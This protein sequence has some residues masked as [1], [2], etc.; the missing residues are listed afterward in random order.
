[1]KKIGKILAYFLAILLILAVVLI[2]RVDRQPYQETAYYQNTMARIDALSLSLDPADSVLQAGWSLTNMTPDEPAPLVGYS[3]RGDY[4]FVADSSFIRTLLLSSAREQ[5]VILGYDLLIVHPYLA[6]TV[7]KAIYERFP[8]ID[9]VYFNASH[10]HS[11]LGGY[12]PGLMGKIA[13]GGYD[14]AIVNLITSQSIQGIQKAYEHLNTVNVSFRKTAAPQ[15]VAN[16]LVPTDPI[17]PYIRQIKF[18]NTR[19]EQLVFM[20]Y[21]AHATCLSSKFMGLSADYT[22]L[23]S[24]KLEKEGL[25]D[26][27]FYAAGT[28]GS[29]KPLPPGDQASDVLTYAEDL[30]NTLLSDT[31]SFQKIE[32]KGLAYQRLPIDLREAHYRIAENWRLRPWLFDNLFGATN[33]H[34][35][36]LQIGSLQLIGSS[37]ELSGVFYASLDSLADQVDKQL[38]ITTF[39]GGYIGYITPD[40]YY[41]SLT[42]A[43]VRDMNWFGPYNGAY[44]QEMLEALIKK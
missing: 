4:E 21:T 13:F 44:F 27:V 1:M 11:G 14:E 15:Y 12:M 20:T 17:D 29:H 25:A 36:I 24:R 9:G 32:T 42:K 37:G 16:R 23:M 10:T 30:A 22:G 33:A 18:E 6:E 41:D 2:T 8:E 39:N 28:V 7:E 43:E 31:S 38:V 19:N 5:V 35:D 34:F 3:P 26:R 40:K